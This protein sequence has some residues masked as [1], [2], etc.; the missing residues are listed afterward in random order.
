MCNKKK[1]H[2]HFLYLK[3]FYLTL[4]SSAL[5]LLWCH[6]TYRPLL[7]TISTSLVLLILHGHHLRW[8]SFLKM[9]N[10]HSWNMLMQRK[11]KRKIFDGKECYQTGLMFSRTGLFTSCSEKFIKELTMPWMH[12]SQFHR[13]ICH[14]M[15]HCRSWYE[16]FLFNLIS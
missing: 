12:E 3:S 5:K 14:K 13:E 16:F 7:T 10:N 8:T 9:N 1:I 4:Q 15:K 11:R 2:Y 6:A